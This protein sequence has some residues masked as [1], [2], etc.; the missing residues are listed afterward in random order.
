MGALS[1]SLCIKGDRSERGERGNGR[2]YSFPSIASIAS[3]AFLQASFAWSLELRFAAGPAHYRFQGA[4]ASPTA[5][6]ESTTVY[7]RELYLEWEMNTGRKP[8]QPYKRW[9]LE[10]LGGRRVQEAPQPVVR[11]LETM[12]SYFGWG[13]HMPTGFSFEAGPAAVIQRHF[14]QDP[15]TSQKL[16]RGIA[17]VG[18][19]FG[20]FYTQEMG[21]WNL[22]AAS[23]IA[24]LGFPRRQS[25][26]SD[27]EV[28]FD[29]Q[30]S[31]RPWTV[32]VQ[33]KT[34]IVQMEKDQDRLEPLGTVPQVI[35]FFRQGET[36]IKVMTLT[37]KR[38]L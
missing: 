19:Y 30:L 37:V 38:T 25:S 15:P 18:T 5:L 7:P 22:G 26:I 4:G 11:R 1:G 31:G 12:I 14:L 9:E 24:V 27:I 21:L 32:G 6:W 34:S 33:F 2:F 13:W 8:D 35:T 3:I 10:Y 23:T 36:D 28:F 29:R 16:T 17:R 20:A